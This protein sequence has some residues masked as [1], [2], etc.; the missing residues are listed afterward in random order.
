[1][2]KKSDLSINISNKAIRQ[3][4]NIMNENGIPEGYSLRITVEGD[5]HSGI[6]YRLGFDS[7]PKDSDILIAFTGLNIVVD[8]ESASLLPGTTIDFDE[9]G[10]CG[11]FVFNNPNAQNKCS[12]NN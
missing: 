6:S 4:Q 11:G 9:E 3:F 8:P 1:M 2:E 5:K 10:C 7:T 12:C